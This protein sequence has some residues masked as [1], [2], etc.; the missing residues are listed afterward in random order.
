MSINEKFKNKKTV[1]SFEIFPPKQTSSLNTVYN[2]IDALAHLHPDYISVTYGAGG[3]SK[4]KTVE[5]SSI[6]KNKYNIDSLAHLTCISST[7][8][9]IDEILFNLKENNINN[10]LALR[11]DIPHDVVFSL[12][13]P[14]E[15]NYS[16]D[17]VAYIKSKGDFCVAAACYPE[18]HL[19]SPTKES[20]WE[21][22]QYK[23]NLGTDFLIS[24]LF[25]EN[26]Y[27]YQLNDHLKEK[28]IN[29]PLQAG[30]M[31]ITNKAQINKIISLCG[32]KLPKRYE[33]IINK[34]GDSPQALQDAGI[35]YA[36]EQIIDLLANGVDGIHIYTMNKPEIAKQIVRNISSVINSINNI[37]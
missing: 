23:I 19:D 28:G 31:P 35:A 18:G 37:Y 30:I 27:F 12:P 5:I 20:D 34:F 21:N 24:Q 3:T 29:T 9:E 33:N 22:L 13:N 25:F 16:S 6:I 14:I 1:I 15:F 32:A 17:L 7:K 8:S 11:G 26:K 36:T 4:D 2:T 10:V